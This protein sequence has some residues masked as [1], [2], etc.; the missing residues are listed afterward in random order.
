VQ[1]SHRLIHTARSFS[2]TIAMHRLDPRKY[3]FKETWMLCDDIALLYRPNPDH[4][5]ATLDCY[6]PGQGAKLKK[7][8]EQYWQDSRAIPEVGT[9]GI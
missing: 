4:Y 8:F 2:S 9:L 5:E 3:N 7:Q 6:A 1:E